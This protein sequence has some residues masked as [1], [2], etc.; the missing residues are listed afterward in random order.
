M[1]MLI[2]ATTVITAFVVIVSLNFHRPEKSV[3][4][5]VRHCHTI[6]DPQFQLEMDAMLGPAVLGGNGIS[7]LQNGDEIFP[8]MLEAIR[9]ATSSITFET[10][11]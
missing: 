8:A 1:W 7:A 10:Y 11:I 4:H 9:G 6:D 5:H 2:L 3:R